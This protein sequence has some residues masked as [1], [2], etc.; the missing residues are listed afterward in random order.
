[1]NATNTLLVVGK[2]RL[3]VAT[4][5]LCLLCLLQVAHFSKDVFRNGL[6]LEGKST[7]LGQLPCWVKLPTGERSRAPLAGPD[8]LM[9]THDALLKN[10]RQFFP[11]IGQVY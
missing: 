8:P 3:P 5:W 9:V 2:P 1:M 10:G 6:F 11:G 7:C 4:R